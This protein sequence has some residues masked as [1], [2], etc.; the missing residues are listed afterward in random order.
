MQ[1]V[2]ISKVDYEPTDMDIM[3][4]EGIS[5]SNSLTSVEFSFPKISSEE[6]LDSDYQHD[7]SLK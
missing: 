4:A 5:L 1:A 3:Y 7:P 6:S 2:E